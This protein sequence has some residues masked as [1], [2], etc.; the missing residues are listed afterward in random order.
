VPVYI[1]G[2]VVAVTLIAGLAALVIWPAIWAKE[3]TRREAA[4]SVLESLLRSLENALKAIA[5]V[6]RSRRR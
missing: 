5:P 1:A 6:M 2:A 3:A 4:Q